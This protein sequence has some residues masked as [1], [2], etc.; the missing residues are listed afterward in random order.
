MKFKRIQIIHST[1]IHREDSTHVQEH[2]QIKAHTFSMGEGLLTLEG[3]G[4]R[5]GT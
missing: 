4:G 2:M 1:Y 5:K 3:T